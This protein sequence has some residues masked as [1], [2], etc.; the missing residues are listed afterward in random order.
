MRV[1]SS[2]LY[3]SVSRSVG[4]LAR[5]ADRQRDRQATLHLTSSL[6]F[7][8]LIL[9]PFFSLCAF[10]LIF[11]LSQSQFQSR[12][13]CSHHWSF[14]FFCLCCLSP[15]LLTSCLS[16]SPSLP[17]VLACVLACVLARTA[18]GC[19]SSVPSGWQRS[20]LLLLLATRS[21]AT[22][23]AQPERER[24]LSLHPLS[25]IHKETASLSLSLPAFLN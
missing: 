24:V 3:R 19:H 25:S 17:Y 20:L 6:L 22:N 14:L 5:E 15:S 13:C 21:F 4:R 1:V 16:S 12:L 10:H 8:C 2:P 23:R 9:L 18:I 11:L 7:A